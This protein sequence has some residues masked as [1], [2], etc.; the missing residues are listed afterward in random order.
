MAKTTQAAPAAET[1]DNDT[2]EV[3]KLP[4][5]GN[6]FGK[7]PTVKLKRRV[8]VPILSW[9][10]GAT[11]VFSPLTVITQ[12]KVIDEKKRGNDDDGS[13]QKPADIM[14]VMGVNGS[15]RLLVVG[16]VIKGVLNDEY[17]DGSYVG[18]WFQA[19]KFEPNRARK[20]RYATYEISEIEDPR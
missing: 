15:V 20:Q 2:G 10:E 8:S 16:T 1:I 12:G 19:T 4:V 3:V 17:P 14:Q 13:P 5:T 11:L 9:P 7:L 18:L 6:E